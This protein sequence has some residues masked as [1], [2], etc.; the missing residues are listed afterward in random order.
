M[1]RRWRMRETSVDHSRQNVKSSSSEW[2][3]SRTTLTKHT[4]RLR[5]ARRRRRQLKMIR[6]ACLH[7]WRKRIS[8]LTLWGASS[9]RLG[10]SWGSERMS[11]RRPW[12]DRVM[13]TENVELSRE[14]R[15][16]SSRRRWKSLRRIMQ[17]L[18]SRGKE[19]SCSN[20]KSMRSSRRNTAWYLRSAWYT[21]RS[22]RHSRLTWM[23]SG[24]D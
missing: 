16:V 2:S 13:M 6:L 19:R 21:Y 9:T 11:W 14:R 8:Y 20:K 22:Y 10:R 1:P 23:S 12:E 5:N 24:G 4:W 18:N 7:L 15:K 3:A 17:S